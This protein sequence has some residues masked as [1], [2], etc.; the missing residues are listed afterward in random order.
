[1]LDLIHVDFGAWDGEV[2]WQRV[3]QGMVDLRA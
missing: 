1:M 2:L 3:A